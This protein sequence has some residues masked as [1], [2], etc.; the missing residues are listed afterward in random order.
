MTL[1]SLNTR[2]VKL[3]RKMTLMGLALLLIIV[4]LFSSTRWSAGATGFNRRPAEMD[5]SIP[6]LQGAEAITYLK[7]HRLYDSLRAALKTTGSR[8]G[9]KSV[10]AQSFD[11]EQ[12]LTASDGVTFDMFGFSVA[13]S[14]S[15][16]VVGARGDS[17]GSTSFGFQG[18]AYVFNRQGGSWAEV[19]KLTASD[20][21]AGDSFGWSVAFS[22]STIVVGAPF[23]DIGG[24]PQQGS[25]YVFNRHGGDWVETQKLTASDGA[26]DG[27]FGWSVAV[28]GSTIVVGATNE[29]SFNF[30][31]GSAY[32][33][34]RQ[35]RGWVEQKLTTSD[36]VEGDSFGFSVAVSGSTV[37][38]GARND[39]I[40]GNFIQGS[41][42]VFN[43]QGGS[44]VETQKLTASDGAAIEQFGWSVAVS[45][46]T[47]VVGVVGDDT[48]G[49]DLNQ[50]S[51]YVFNRQGGSWVETQVL[52]ASDGAANDVFG[53]SVAVSG[54]TI[55]VGAP[56]D[57]ISGLIDH[58]SAYVFNHQGG[59]WIETQKLIVSDVT[60][61][62]HFG[63]SVAVSG[64]TIVLGAPEDILGSKFFQG[65]AYIFEP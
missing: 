55:V 22:G 16:A 59:G 61:E 2:Y 19:Q 33:F 42:Y 63:F 56:F 1:K 39:T 20:G 40:G 23:D 15:T 24:N 37:V 48:G 18:A 28:S 41:A 5:S 60:A 21:T 9:D 35:G 4:S 32:V 58:G 53:R 3:I 51:V 14:G 6:A 27:H 47:I 57:D 30:D 36:E 50:G 17:I 54:S 46:S 11:N 29:L 45:G 13:V 10:L 12:K 38:V 26:A 65:S 43:R 7:E 25:V 34:D 44:W 49:G 62:A 52:T 31:Q 64:S 8:L